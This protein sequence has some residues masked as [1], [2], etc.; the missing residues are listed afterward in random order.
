MRL[1]KLGIMAIV[2]LAIM[3]ALAGVRTVSGGDPMDDSTYSGIAITSVNGRAVVT[4]RCESGDNRPR[5]Y[6]QHNEFLTS[7]RNKFSL[8]YRVDKLVKQDHTFWALS[9]GKAGLLITPN[10]YVY[11]ERYGPAP[12]YADANNDGMRRAKLK[13]QWLLYVFNGVINDF[14]VGNSALVRVWDFRDKSY[15]Y[16]FSL[17]GV[18]AQLDALSACYTPLPS[19]F[20]LPN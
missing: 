2:T 10:D 9:S 19:E 17:A 7:S 14:A 1:V 3:P 6:F 8:S 5:I 20:L 11:K 13:D 18:M 16:E 15:T 4:F 12:T